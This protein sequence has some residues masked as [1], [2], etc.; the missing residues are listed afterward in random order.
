M[1]ILL[2]FCDCIIIIHFFIYHFFNLIIYDQVTFY[3][4]FIEWIKIIIISIFIFL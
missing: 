4:Y 1:L 2:I 3:M